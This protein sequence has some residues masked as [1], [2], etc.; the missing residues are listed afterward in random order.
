MRFLVWKE[1]QWARRGE[2]HKSFSV[3]VTPDHAEGLQAYS[4]RQASICRGLHGSFTRRWTGVP[5]MIKRARKESKDRSLLLKRREEE[6]HVRLEAAKRK[7]TSK[8]TASLARSKKW[9][10]PRIL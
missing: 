1:K 9:G 7:G 8:G 10:V 2:A 6:E 3:L 4:A 5:E